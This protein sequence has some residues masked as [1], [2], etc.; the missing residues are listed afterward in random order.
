MRANQMV[1]NF[2]KA[3]ITA[4]FFQQKPTQ[5]LLSSDLYLVDDLIQTLATKHDVEYLIAE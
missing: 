4:N 3:V 1:V 2:P 5:R